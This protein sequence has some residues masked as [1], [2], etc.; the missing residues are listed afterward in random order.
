VLA[1]ASMQMAFGGLWMLLFATLAGEWPRLAFNMRTSMAMIYLTIFGSIAAYTAYAYALKHLP[2]STVSMYTYA[3]P[4]IAV[5][6]G[7]LLLGEPFGARMLVAAAIIVLG[8]LIVGVRSSA[9]AG[10]KD[11]IAVEPIQVRRAS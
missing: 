6:L 3:N 2:V 9:P 7:T 4:V 10:R 11:Q 1:G 8:M 5:V